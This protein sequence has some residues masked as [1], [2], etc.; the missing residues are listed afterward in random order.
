MIKKHIIKF[1]TL[2]TF[3]AL[4]GCVHYGSHEASTIQEVSLEACKHCKL[5]GQV[6][7]ESTYPYLSLGLE[8]ATER[9]KKQA[10]SIGATHVVWTD[11]NTNGVPYV[12]GRA[13]SCPKEKRL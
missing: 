12:V 4:T 7:G 5:V 10:V 2:I 11:K 9:A 6:Q 8:I 3:A 1:I 13:Y